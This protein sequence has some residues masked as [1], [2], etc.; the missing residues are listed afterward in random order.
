MSDIS[1]STIGTNFTLY[2]EALKDLIKTVYNGTVVY[3]PSD[4]AFEYALN[5]TKNKIKFPMIS[6]YHDNN[7][8]LDMGRNSFQ[9]YKRGMLFENAIKVRDDNMKLTGETNK[10][11]SKSVQNLYITMRYIIDVYGTDRFSTEKVMQELLFWLFDNQQV[12]IVYQGQ[13]LSF[14]FDISP[15]IVDNTDLVS[16]HSNGKLYRMSMSISTHIALFRSV[17]YF[18]ALIPENIVTVGTENN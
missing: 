2:S 5:Q 13:P 12:D 10:K 3:E 7:I 6:I 11:I 4:V 17:D 9:T 16:Y 15:N 8:E 1:N 14:T 18:N